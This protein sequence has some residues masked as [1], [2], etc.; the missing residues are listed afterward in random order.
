M[1]RMFLTMNGES[2]IYKLRHAGF[3]SIFPA[4]AMVVMLLTGGLHC[5][6]AEKQAERVMLGDERFEEYLPLLSGKRVAVFC[7][8]SGIVGDQVKGSKL[9]DALKPFGGVFPCSGK[10]EGCCGKGMD[11]RRDVE[12]M[13]ALS[14]IPFAEPARPGEAIEYGP[15]LV[16][17]LLQKEV[18]VTA[19]FS[20]EHGFRGDA[21]A[22]EMVD[23]GVDPQ[24]GVEI[25]SLYGTGL[26]LPGREQMERFDVLVVDI[27]DVGL[28]FYTYYVSMFHLM[29]ACAKHGK[30]VV[31]LDRPNPNGFYV[32]GPVLDMR[33]KSGVGW[34]PIPTVH[35][36]TLGELALMINGEGWLSDAVIGGSDDAALTCDLTVIPCRNYT[37]RSRYSLIL[38]PSP[39][40]KDMRAVY[41]YASTCYFEG[42][43]VSVGRGT[44]F[45]FE[46]YGHPA[47]RECSFSFT[48]LS[49]P[50]AKNPPLLGKTC[51]G[52]DLRRKSLEQVWEEK[53]SFEYVLDAYRNLRIGAAFFRKDRY[54]D[55]LAG[56]D[57]IR[58]MIEADVSAEGI[59]ARWSEDVDRFKQRRRP[60]LLYEE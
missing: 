2:V 3:P 13:D 35:G 10:E 27:Q 49:M 47:M 8:Q 33:F 45:P 7:N 4:I 46:V 32:D 57:W 12:A 30:P 5:R 58:E 21:D 34:L 22:G 24:T 48:P 11:D 28:R 6:G 20:P 51:F 59:R 1:N 16:D 40:F 31:V 43:V 26:R 50:G 53:M 15:H 39:N 38:P 25:F 52:A 41:L 29:Q 18:Q 37:H 9:A 54:F 60:Y 14:L 23:S 36:M 19:I 56:V 42:T 44:L 17:V 55:L